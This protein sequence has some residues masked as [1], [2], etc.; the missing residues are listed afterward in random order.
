MADNSNPAANE[1][2]SRIIALLDIHFGPGSPVYQFALAAS[3]RNIPIFM[4]GGTLRDLYY[5]GSLPRD[6]DLVVDTEDL[7]AFLEPFRANFVRTTRFGGWQF[8]FGQ[9]KLDIWPLAATWAFREG[10]V[11]PAT[12]ATLP[13]T[14]FLN[15][16]AIAAE[17]KP[18]PMQPRRIYES[19]FFQ[20]MVS[21]TLEINLKVNPFPELCVVRALLTAARFDFF[22]GPDLAGYLISY[23]PKLTL[24]HLREIQITHYGDLKSEPEELMSWLEFLELSRASARH[25]L[26]LPISQSRRLAIQGSWVV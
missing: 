8:V 15:I 11:S 12:F 2:E 13:K 19:C 9:W 4:F 26:K 17:L 23:R 18:R 5:Y 7:T 6:L 24:R 22:I 20:G 14:T 10:I 25:R 1:L 16:E 21:K 3:M